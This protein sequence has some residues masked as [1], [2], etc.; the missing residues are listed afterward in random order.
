MAENVYIIGIDGGGSRIRGILYDPNNQL[1]LKYMEYPYSS[2]Y[3]NVGFRRAIRAIRDLVDKISFVEMRS[4]IV[5]GLA[6]LDSKFDWILWRKHLGK[7]FNDYDLRHDVEIV[8]YSA[9]Y[10]KPGIVV[11]AGTGFNVYGWDGE[12]GYYAGNWGWKVGDDASAYTIGRI[13]LN[14]AVK[15]HDGRLKNKRL[16]KTVL[17]YLGLNDFDELIMW[18]Y[19]ATPEEIASISI[20]ACEEY[21]VEES[22]MEVFANSVSES[23]SSIDA[24]LDK[25][26]DIDMDI[27][28]SGGLFNCRY[29][30]DLFRKRLYEH[31]INVKNKVNYPLVGSVIIGLKDLGFDLEWKNIDK[32]IVEFLD[33]GMGKSYI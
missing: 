19:K 10:G 20:L 6:G 5:L 15:C 26:H 7:I 21:M 28:Y 22:F 11:I 14:K 32:K 17:E 3:H 2:N 25:F 23:I 12:K 29:Y 8:L 18:I 27:Y 24:V 33:R 30:E 31:G 1:P 9:T 13:I 16:L 4:Y